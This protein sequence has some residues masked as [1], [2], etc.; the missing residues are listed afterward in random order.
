[1]V[2]RRLKEELHM[3]KRKEADVDKSADVESSSPIIRRSKIDRY[4]NS[5]LMGYDTPCRVAARKG[6]IGCG[7]ELFTLT[8]GVNIKE[9]E[10]RRGGGREN[11]EEACA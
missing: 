5:R 11:N 6:P 2:P 8:M 3:E 4:R 9:R 1:M 7:D 10:Q